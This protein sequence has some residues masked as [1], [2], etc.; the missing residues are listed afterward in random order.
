M[1][2]PVY[3]ALMRF[4]RDLLP[5][6]ESFIKAGRQNFDR[7]HFEQP[8]IVVDSLAGDVPLTSSESY[9]GGTEQMTY[10]EYVSRPITFD[11]YGPTAVDLCRRF[12]LL[13]RSESSLQLQQSLGVTVWH[14]GAATDVKAL[15][16]QQYG[17]RMQLQCQVHY[18]PSVVVDILRID[19]AQ[20]RII[21]ERGLIYEQ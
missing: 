3:I 18:C 11:F 15:T 17:E 4:I 9:D 20:L 6:P 13:A 21:G 2:D 16:G 12:R 5:H 1:I 19:T 10:A 7:T 14:P 8:Y